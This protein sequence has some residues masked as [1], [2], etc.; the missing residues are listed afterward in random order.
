MNRLTRKG[1]RH[2]CPSIVLATSVMVLVSLG[3]PVVA[4]DASPL[5]GEPT[6]DRQLIAS[7]STPKEALAL[8]PGDPSLDSHIIAD[9]LLRDVGTQAL[10]VREGI[11]VVRV[12]GDAAC[13]YSTVQ[14]AIDNA[15]PPPA[16]TVI[17]I[18]RNGEYARQAL[19]I[20]DKNITLEGGYANCSAREPDSPTT[21]LDGAG[22]SNRP[23]IRIRNKDDDMRMEVALHRLTIQGGTTTTG[24]F[25][26]SESLRNGGGLNIRG[27][28]MVD[29]SNT[30]V[31]DNATTSGQHPGI[32]CG[33]PYS[34]S[35][36]G[37]YFDG[38]GFRDSTLRLN[39]GTSVLNNAADGEGKSGIYD[40]LNGVGGGI[41]C[42]SGRILLDH[43][44]IAIAHN[45]TGGPAPGS[46]GGVYL[47]RDCVFH[48][49]AGG[50]LSGIL[51]NESAVHGGGIYT[52]T[53]RLR[54]HRPNPALRPVIALNRSE[55]HGGGIY[56]Q[57]ERDVIL[58]MSIDGVAVAS[59]TSGGHGGGVY[60]SGWG[61]KFELMN[62]VIAGNLARGQGGG[63][64]IGRSDLV[65]GRSAD[66]CNVSDLSRCSR[67]ENNHAEGHGG[68]LRILGGITEM[69]QTLISGNSSDSLGSV[70]LV[71]GGFT[72][73]LMEA[74][75]IHGNHGSS[76]LFQLESQSLTSLDWSTIAGNRRADDPPLQ[77]F[78]LHNEDH[79]FIRQ[80][81]RLRVRGSIIWEPGA[82]M[83]NRTGPTFTPSNCTIGHTPLEESG[84]SVGSRF[85][86]HI[87]PRLRNPATG[88]LRLRPDSP[89][90]DYCS[91]GQ[92]GVAPEFTDLFGNTR[93]VAYSEPTTEAPNPGSGNFDLGIHEL[94]PDQSIP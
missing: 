8:L 80:N 15:P 24:Y 51:L 44:S 65:I 52:H 17:R 19:Q 66:S 16:A 33:D 87:N 39:A 49:Q 11:N 62:T 32:I 88:D 27:R 53:G 57:T 21:V 23:V 76:R 67:L 64:S 25:R 78:R 74:V 81:T 43:P 55:M 92:V 94:T 73:L 7:A 84:L 38:D 77:V 41:F 30:V 59:N 29:L 68:A 83:V 31:R 90:I 50:I 35:G 34:N 56:V 26:C 2:R 18:A 58:H 91:S 22:G 36:G 89:A 28:V 85:Y 82:T 54:F 6:R 14:D 12:G 40:N 10:S 79:Q 42:R 75:A 48:S 60:F 13:H 70:A 1:Q 5:T 86:S 71:R 46:G 72:Q 93:G 9:W 45:R 47:E 4:N 3:Q 63:I 69:H 20:N 61:S 37:I